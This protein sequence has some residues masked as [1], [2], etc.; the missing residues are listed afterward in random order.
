MCAADS[1]I[2]HVAIPA[3]AG[4]ESDEE[5]DEDDY[6]E[7]DSEEQEELPCGPISPGRCVSLRIFR[8]PEHEFG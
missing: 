6:E 2:A 4:S 1:G 8:G 3:D 5:D 7:D